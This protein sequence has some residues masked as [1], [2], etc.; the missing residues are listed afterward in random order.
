M[1]DEVTATNFVFDIPESGQEDPLTFDRYQFK[2]AADWRPFAVFAANVA[3]FFQLMMIV[4]T[5]GR[6][7]L[8]MT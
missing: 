2:K 7:S 5:A 1:V 3:G 8:H 6:R 4:S